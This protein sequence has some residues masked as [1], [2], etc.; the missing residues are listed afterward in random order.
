MTDSPPDT[1]R[2]PVVAAAMEM[3]NRRSYDEISV[4][5]IAVAAGVT[6]R[7]CYRRYGSKLGIYLAALHQ[8]VDDAVDAVTRNGPEDARGRLRYVMRAYLD[9]LT[10]NPSGHLYLSAQ[11]FRKD[12]VEQRFRENLRRTVT[13]VLLKCVGGDPPGSLPSLVPG[14]VALAESMFCDWIRRGVPCRDELETVLCDMFFAVVE[15]ADGAGG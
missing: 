6:G 1:H 8:L 12:G 11:A 9:H 10:A 5:D 2:R 15:T 7:E 13:R 4:E 3:F 14:W